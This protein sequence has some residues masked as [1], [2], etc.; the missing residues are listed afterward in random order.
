MGLD[1]AE[2]PRLEIGYLVFEAMIEKQTGAPL[3][4]GVKRYLRVAYFQGAAGMLTTS[5]LIGAL[6]EE[7]RQDAL[8][9]AVREIGDNLR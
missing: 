6:P 5:N 8:N 9:A 3:P 2:F 1:N 4:E 7:M